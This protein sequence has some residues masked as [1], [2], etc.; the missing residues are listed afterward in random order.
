MP[1]RMRQQRAG[2]GTS[3][4]RAPSFRYRYKSRYRSLDDAEKENKIEGKVIDIVN[5]T[6]RTAPIMIV[7]YKTGEQAIIPAPYGIKVGDVVEAGANATIKAGNVLPLKS[8]PAGTPIYNIELVPGDGGK[9]VRA[10]GTAA[11]VVAHEENRV[12]IKLPSK[13]LKQLNPNC[14]ATI[15]LVAGFGRKEKPIVKA[16]KHYHMA[17]ARGK[18]WP[19]VSGVAMNAVSHPFGGKRRSTQSSKKK[20]AP[21]NAPPGRKVGSIAAKKT[22]RKKR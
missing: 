13:E 12:I 17:K 6:A 4:F 20:V 18:Y 3:V 14:R 5:D 16:G 10:S 2:K 22:G 21:R 11:R 8:I 9:L 7:E 19:R 15:G 1:K